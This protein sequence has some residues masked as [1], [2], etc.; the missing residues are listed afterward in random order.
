MILQ[1]A[2]MWWDLN[3]IIPDGWTFWCLLEGKSVFFFTQGVWC[4]NYSLRPCVCCRSFQPPAMVYFQVTFS[5][6]MFSQNLLWAIC[7][8][9]Y[10]GKHYSGHIIIFHQPKFPWNKGMSLPKRYLLG[11]QVVW[12]RYNLTRWFHQFPLMRNHQQNQPSFPDTLLP[13][14][15][16]F[17]T[18]FPWKKPG[19]LFGMFLVI[20]PTTTPCNGT[21]KVLFETFRFHR[22][23]H[24]QRRGLSV[25]FFWGW[26]TNTSRAASLATTRSSNNYLP[27]SLA[28]LADISGQMTSNRYH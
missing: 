17:H 11:A 23:H 4:S 6:A 26:N 22:G 27:K 24:R 18:L 5:C 13:W 28:P 15:W 14:T 19:W 10:I 7:K 12:G 1:A 9:T 21:A 2:T 16:K 20:P 8:R 3:D 25:V